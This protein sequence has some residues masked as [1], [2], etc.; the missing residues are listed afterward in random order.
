MPFAQRSVVAI[1][2]CAVRIALHAVRRRGG[3]AAQRSSPAW[4]R[5][6]SST[7]IVPAAAAQQRH[8]PPR[9]ATPPPCPPAS[10]LAPGPRPGRAVPLVPQVSVGDPFSG[11]AVGDPFCGRPLGLVARVFAPLVA[12][13]ELPAQRG[14]SL[15]FIEQMSEESLM[16]FDDWPVSR[17]IAGHGRGLRRNGSRWAAP[18]GVGVVGGGG[19][20]RE[21]GD[22]AA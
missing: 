1:I 4:A 15:R 11:G 6:S 14:I 22:E 13:K 5:G 7:G 8:R 20:P 21:G 19:D 9:H 3:G 10:P 12:P 18:G 17:R 2:Q 16:S